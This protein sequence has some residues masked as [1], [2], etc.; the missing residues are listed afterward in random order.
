MRNVS[1]LF[2]IILILGIL[3]ATSSKKMYAQNNNTKIKVHVQ[4]NTKKNIYLAV[5]YMPC[6]TFNS[7]FINKYWYKI[8]A[9]ERAFIF[10]TDNAVFYYYAE[11]TTTNFWG[12]R[13]QMGGGLL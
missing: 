1:K 2:R 11:T 13:E 5:R 8:N 7:S 10:E 3:I 9:G 4:N 6:G 12:Q